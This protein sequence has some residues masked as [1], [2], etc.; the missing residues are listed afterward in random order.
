MGELPSCPLHHQEMTW[1]EAGVSKKT[2]KAYQGFWSCKTRTQDGKFCSEKPPVQTADSGQKFSSGLN[3]DIKR[4]DDERRQDYIIRQTIA[5]AFIG[6]GMMNVHENEHLM[7]AWVEWI[8]GK[9]HPT[10]KK[11]DYHF[12]PDNEN[13]AS[14]K[15]III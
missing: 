5:K 9:A 11:G 13:S 8:K 10:F 7:N 6:Q 2:G 1:V 15:E 4:K 3:G 14:L 12:T